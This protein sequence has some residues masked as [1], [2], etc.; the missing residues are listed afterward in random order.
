M[1]IEDAQASVSSLTCPAVPAPLTD[2][3]QEDLQ[4]DCHLQNGDPRLLGA[5]SA[6]NGV[7][8]DAAAHSSHLPRTPQPVLPNSSMEIEDAQASVS[9][10]TCP[11]VPAPLTDSTQ[12]LQDD[13]HRQNGDPRLLGASCAV[14][15][16]AQ[17]TAV[18]SGHL[19]RTP[20]PV[21]PNSSME[22]EDAQ[23]SVSFLTCPAVPAPLT[24]S[25]Q[26][27]LQDDCHLQ[28]DSPYSFGTL[29]VGQC[30]EVTQ[31]KQRVAR[32]DQEIA[33]HKRKVNNL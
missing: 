12:G 32:L 4:D 5:S 29:Q 17:D 33:E 30:E 7:A 28:N 6:V 22:I 14:N 10:L 8:Q 13:C 11:A 18:H 15:G 31:L 26:E 2:S 1:E 21:L 19:P 25:T 24:D 23:A 9:S 27:D 20:Q 16:V 3:T